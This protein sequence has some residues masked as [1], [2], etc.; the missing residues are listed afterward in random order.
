MVR[1]LLTPVTLPTAYSLTPATV[2]WDA[3]DVAN[4]NA[5]VMT[6]REILLARNVNAGA[7]TITITSVAINGRLG[8]ISAYSIGA[9]LTKVFQQFPFAGWRQSDSRL[10]IDV[11]HADVLL[12]VLKLT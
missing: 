5:F 9:G 8:H 2:T 11:G 6:G 3:G 1:T 10:W 7:Q 12:A 4:G